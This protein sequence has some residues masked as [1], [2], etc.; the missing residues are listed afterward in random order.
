MKLEAHHRLV[1]ST[2]SALDGGDGTINLTIFFHTLM[3]L[4]QILEPLDVEGWR[5]MSQDVEG[6]PK[7][8]WVSGFKR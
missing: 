3:I 2:L 1:E 7:P 4:F 6:N 5:S 8:L